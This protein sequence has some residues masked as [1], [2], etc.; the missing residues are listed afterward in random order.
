MSSL[1]LLER[2][3]AR[4]RDGK[5]LVAD[6]LNVSYP[7][8]ISFVRRVANALIADG[9][10]A[11]ENAAVLSPNDPFAFLASLGVHAAGLSYVPLNPGSPA[12]DIA[13]SLRQ[14]D[15]MALIYHAD[16]DEVVARIR[17][18]LPLVRR[19]V[20]I[21]AGSTA[22]VTI[23]DYIA[24]ARADRP[25]A[26]PTLDQIAYIGQTGGTT[27]EPKG[28]MVS[29][30][31]VYGFVT[32]F[33]CEIIDP[34]PVLLA[35]TPLTHAA[36]MLTLPIIASGGRIVIMKKPDPARFIS[37][38]ES[39][40]VTI[41]FLPPTVIYRLLDIPGIAQRNFA[42]LRHFIYGAAPMSVSRLKQALATFGP[43]MTQFYGQTECHSLI[44]AMRPEDH[45]VG[46]VLGGEIASDARLSACGRPS[47][48]TSVV[49]MDENGVAVPAGQRGEICVQ[50][51]LAMTGY[52]K[53]PSA[54]A[55]VMRNGFIHTGDVGF[56]DED[57]LLHIVDRIKDMIISGGFNVYPAE[58]EEVLRG[59][60]AVAECAVIGVPHAEWG[61][62]VVAAIELKP[63]QTATVAEILA[64]AREHLGG[65][66]TP[67][68]I[69]FW[70]SL[71]RSA[72]G[73][74]L[75]KA[76]KESWGAGR[77]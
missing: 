25:G 4:S 59:H 17:S 16:M 74:V 56:L 63:G 29:W 40:K 51:D 60:P 54:T 70:P 45:Y 48:G 28:V 6:E 11:G 76:V 38:I 30:R 31:A 32:K 36:G 75:K 42:S 19:F 61:E 22:D 53:N 3:A 66:K 34:A 26:A 27:G 20:R 68:A 23:S 67:K 47:I 14:F 13:R 62:A 41:T 55:E 64:H 72:V 65:V 44:A 49:I 21:G 24:D 58:V 46:G 77:T 35:A 7:E 73:K 57:G 9:F 50:S 39:E 43:V 10:K 69:E 1:T 52:Y 8:A 15:C 33:L 37:L 18:D 5:F 71:P 12:A 2:G